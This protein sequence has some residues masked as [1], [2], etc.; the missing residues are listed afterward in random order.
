MLEVMRTTISLP[1]SL[2]EAADELARRLG[3][4]RDELYA[5]AITEHLRAHHREAVTEALS[6]IYEQEPS[7]L[8][9]VVAAIQATSV[10][11]DDW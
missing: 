1:D 7:G 8:D 5:T 10:G 11:E 2:F 9:P 3:I 4:S 6:R